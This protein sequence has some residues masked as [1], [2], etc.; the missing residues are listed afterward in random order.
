MH[1]YIKLIIYLKRLAY[2][3]A[4]KI[5]FPVHRDFPPKK[6]PNF[7][8]SHAQPTGFELQQ[9]I[10]RFGLRKYCEKILAGKPHSTI[11][12]VRNVNDQLLL[13]Y[14][15]RIVSTRRELN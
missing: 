2:I 6:R 15:R 12:S 3:F 14:F 7:D 9:S 10:A 5:F 1:F 11:T 8:I 4:T 13:S